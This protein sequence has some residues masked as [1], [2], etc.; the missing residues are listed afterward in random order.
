MSRRRRR[1]KDTNYDGDIQI[2]FLSK[3]KWKL[4]LKKEER[5]Q[6][7]IM[8]IDRKRN[9]E[10]GTTT[11]AATAT[12]NYTEKI[13]NGLSL[14]KAAQSHMFTKENMSTTPSFGNGDIIMNASDGDL[15]INTY[16]ENIDYDSDDS[17]EFGSPKWNDDGL[18]WIPEREKGSIQ[19]KQRNRNEQALW[20]TLRPS[21][22]TLL[23]VHSIDA[24]SRENKICTD[25]K[26]SCANLYLC[27]SCSPNLKLCGGCI[28]NR[29]VRIL[30]HDIQQIIPGYGLKQCTLSTIT[31]EYERFNCFAHPDTCMKEIILIDLFGITLL[32]ID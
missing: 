11:P 8:E 24:A 23:E 10:V 6:R 20:D 5:T 1:K 26:N 18:V 31:E 15:K 27:Q 30:C 16:G 7:I 22:R 3:K 12:E 25:C 29:H 19:Y 32:L 4:G 21:L 28:S 13:M 9:I 17:V 14:L 2:N